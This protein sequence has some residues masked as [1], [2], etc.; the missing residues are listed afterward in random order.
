MPVYGNPTK[1]AECEDEGTVQTIT[2]TSGSKVKFC[3]LFCLRNTFIRIQLKLT[4][5]LTQVVYIQEDVFVHTSTSAA[6]NY[7]A[8]IIQGRIFIEEKVFG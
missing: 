3:P 7:S 5:W 8:N 6:S 1:M 4:F 2:E